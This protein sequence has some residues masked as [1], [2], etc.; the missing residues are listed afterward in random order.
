MITAVY[1]TLKIAAILIGFAVITTALMNMNDREHDT[2][3]FKDALIIE[4]Y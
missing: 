4:T 2:D 1:L 3:D